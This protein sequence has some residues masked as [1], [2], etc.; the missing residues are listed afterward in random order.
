MLPNLTPLTNNLNDVFAAVWK[1]ING[2]D[3]KNDY[4]RR[5]QERNYI[6]LLEKA[7]KPDEKSKLL[8]IGDTVL[9]SDVPPY[10]EM[11]LEK[12]RQYVESHITTDKANDVNAQHYIHLKKMLSN[13]EKT[14]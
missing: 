6:S 13:I 12:I 3:T 7:L 11:H 8:P 10:V 4:F 5:Q 14:K 1:P 2:S 9:R